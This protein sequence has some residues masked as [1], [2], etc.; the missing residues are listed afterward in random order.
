MVP[1]LV[2][3]RDLHE[4]RRFLTVRR[5]FAGLPK[6]SGYVVALNEHVAAMEVFH[7]FRN[8]G[9][10][11]LRTHDISDVEAGATDAFF[12]SVIARE[13]LRV[14]VPVPP[15]DLASFAGALGWA[16]R[17][18]RW[19]MVHREWHIG[20]SDEVWL[21]PLTQCDG[22]RFAI[23]YVDPAGFID[24]EDEQIEIAS[25]TRIELLT[26]Y[27]HYFQKYGQGILSARST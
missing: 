10:C 18:D 21:G 20:D 25:L 17:A 8:D 27:L 1:P 4:Q 22:E 16:L 15:G 9:L 7:D 5:R 24:D 3:L 2:T 23:R 13:Q 19:V 12:D 11:L 14:P 26:P 6:D